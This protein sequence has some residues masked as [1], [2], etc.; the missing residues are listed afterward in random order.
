[1]DTDSYEK[2]RGSRVRFQ[3]LEDQATFSGWLD[4]LRADRVRIVTEAAPLVQA[5]ERFL[6]QVQ[7]PS[8]DVAFIARNAP[9]PP[10]VRCALG[11]LSLPSLEYE[12]CVE[13]PIRREEMHQEA[14]RLID[15]VDA[16]LNAAGER[17]K[18]LVVDASPGGMGILAWREQE[19]GD[20]VVVEIEGTGISARF[21]ATVRHCR[22]EP[23]IPGAYRVG[24][25]FE[26][27]DGLSLA[28]W[29]ELIDRT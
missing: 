13:T 26:D 17:R 27:P 18:V 22:A 16:T 28:A 12:F 10:S 6:F 24:L 9:A 21:D 1:M 20:P 14:R 5:G 11:S 3:R 7:G 23:Q 25:R 19:V 15:P 2:F 4:L 8:A 29:R